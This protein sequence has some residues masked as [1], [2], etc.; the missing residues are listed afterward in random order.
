MHSKNSKTPQEV[1]NLFKQRD[2]PENFCVVPFV[3]L[4]CNPGGKVGVCRQKGT[5]HIVGD[6]EKNSLEEIWNNEY[7]QKWR[8]EF[9]SGNVEICRREINED[10]CHLGA[11][12]YEYFGD[13]ELNIKQEFPMKKFTANL[14]G[15]CNLECVMCD[16]WKMPNGYYDKGN[17]WDKAQKDIFPYIK[18]VELLS[19]EPF[20]QKDTYKLIDKISG[21]NKDCLWSFTTNAHWRFNKKIKEALDKIKVKNIH[22]SIDSLESKNYSEIRKKGRLK[23]VLQTIDDFVAYEKERMNENKTSMGLSVHFL[24]MQKN[25]QEINHIIDFV[26]QRGIKIILDFLRFPTVYSLAS[27][28]ELQREKILEYYYD[29][30]SPAKLARSMRIIM[31]LVKSLS[32]AGKKKYYMKLMDVYAD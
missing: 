1:L 11:T 9:L 19:G 21:I 23:T 4:I 26:D 17:F 13:V 27:L 32:S 31:P 22:I 28:P 14:N 10:F 12:N 5:E 15:E 16:V 30:L 8:S 3:N 29:N 2:L 24:V 18:E 25:W 7:L 20:L 6:L